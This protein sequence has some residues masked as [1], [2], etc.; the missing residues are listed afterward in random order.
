[1]KLD[2]AYDEHLGYNEGGQC[3]IYGTFGDGSYLNN[4]CSINPWLRSTEYMTFNPSGET[5]NGYYLNFGN[6]GGWTKYNVVGTEERQYQAKNNADGTW[7]TSSTTFTILENTVDGSRLYWTGEQYMN[8]N[9]NSTFWPIMFVQTGNSTSVL[10]ATTM[11]QPHLFQY[12]TFANY[13]SGYYLGDPTPGVGYLEDETNSITAVCYNKVIPGGSVPEKRMFS[14][15]ESAA[16]YT[17]AQCGITE[18][19]YNSMVDFLLAKDAN[20]DPLDWLWCIENVAEWVPGPDK[21]EISFTFKNDPRP[22]NYRSGRFN[23]NNKYCIYF[24]FVDSTS[25]KSI[26]VNFYWESQ[27]IEV[28]TDWYDP[29]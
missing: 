10:S 6:A 17:W 4:M 9:N 26:T 1:M 11:G 27:T 2:S 5:G 14:F 24:R 23:I 25:T 3:V 7:Y 22:T 29:G 19:W 8:V 18:S 13:P 12:F 20:K 15:P 28:I 16:T 21:G